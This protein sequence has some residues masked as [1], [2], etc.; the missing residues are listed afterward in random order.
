MLL[1]SEMS[2]P[3]LRR[4]AEFESWEKGAGRNTEERLVFVFVLVMDDCACARASMSVKCRTGSLESNGL[5]HIAGE[6]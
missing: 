1:A 4:V 3:G 2:M 6:G 5:R